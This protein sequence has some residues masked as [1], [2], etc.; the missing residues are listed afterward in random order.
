[1]S[2][3]T[4]LFKQGDKGDY[5]YIIQEG[6]VE[7]IQQDENE[8]SEVVAVLSTSAVFAETAILMDLH[9]TATART[10]TQTR[11]LRLL[12]ED[13][14]TFLAKENKSKQAFANMILERSRP[15]YLANVTAHQILKFKKVNLHGY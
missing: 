14:V 1:M 4:I 12:R 7:I 3:N 10:L 5:C 9:R 6:Q 15:K 11:L 8:A 2:P 13:L